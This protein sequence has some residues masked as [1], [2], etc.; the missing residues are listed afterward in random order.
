MNDVSLNDDTD[1]TEAF[2][3]NQGR[4]EGPSTFS[5]VIYRII[6]RKND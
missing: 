4:P 5:L 3:L 1:T 6:D 2:D